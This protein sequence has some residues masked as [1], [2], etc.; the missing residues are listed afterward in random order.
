MARKLFASLEKLIISHNCKFNGL[1]FFLNAS[2]ENQWFL[3]RLAT[4][5]EFFCETPRWSTETPGWSIA[6]CSC[7]NLH[8]VFF[9]LVKVWHP[10]D[11][12]QG[13]GNSAALTWQIHASRNEEIRPLNSRLLVTNHLSSDK[14]R[15]LWNHYLQNHWNL[16]YINE[17]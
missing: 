1:L 2:V 5:F 6:Q 16:M 11:W 3:F 12:S 13:G 10:W 7:W 8:D 15:W 9:H 4:E 17:P 14:F